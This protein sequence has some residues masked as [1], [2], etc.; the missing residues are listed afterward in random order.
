M[1]TAFSVSLKCNI[2]ASGLVFLILTITFAANQPTSLETAGQ[3]SG[4]VGICTK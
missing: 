4:G 3:P 1:N 2:L